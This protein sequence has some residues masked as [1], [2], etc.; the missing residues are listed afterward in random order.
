MERRYN[1]RA[2]ELRKFLLS[3]NVGDWTTISDLKHTAQSVRAVC[4]SVKRQK[5]GLFTV[6]NEGLKRC[7]KV[8]RLA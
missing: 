7:V 3:M 4:T 2:T 8:T 1:A 5:R 6:T